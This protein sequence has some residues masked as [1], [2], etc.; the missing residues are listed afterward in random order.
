MEHWMRQAG[1]GVPISVYLIQCCSSSLPHPVLQ[2]QSN[3]LI[4]CSSS[5]LPHAVL[6]FRSGLPHPVLQ[7]HPTSSSVLIPVYFIQYCSSSL[8]DQDPVLQSNLLIQCSSSILPHAVLQFQ[9]TSSSTPVQKTLIS[10]VCFC[11]F[12]FNFTFFYNNMHHYFL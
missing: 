11:T 12:F 4:Q 3:I 8:P 6:R 1:T 10:L 9:S 7:F 2:F 5:I